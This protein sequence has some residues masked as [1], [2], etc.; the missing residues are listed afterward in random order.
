[1]DEKDSDATVDRYYEKREN[2]YAG[3]SVFV[4]A[5]DV[6]R[7]IQYMDRERTPR[8]EEGRRH[9]IDVAACEHERSRLGKGTPNPQQQPNQQ[10][11]K[12]Q[13]QY[14]PNYELMLAQ[15]Q[16]CRPEAIFFRHRSDTVL[17]GAD[18]NGQNHAG[19]R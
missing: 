6:H 8:I 2:E 5:R 18:E 17:H 19:E 10:T 1:M 9:A 11:R 13:R 12:R 3:V 15:S 14:D 7:Q 4:T 16:R